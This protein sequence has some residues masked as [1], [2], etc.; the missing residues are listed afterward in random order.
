MP[1]FVRNLSPRWHNEV[2]GTRWFRTD[3][4]IHTLD[5]HPSSNFKFPDGI[6]GAPDDEKTQDVYARALL[7]AAIKAGIEVLGL[8]PH[9]VR[10]GETD[11]SSATWRIIEVWNNDKDDDGVLF[12]DKIYAVFPGFEPNLADG[13]EGLHLLFLFDPEIGRD[14]YLR[15]FNAVMGA[16]PP[17]DG[18]TLRISTNNASDAFKALEEL[19]KRVGSNWDYLIL[20]PHAFGEKGLFSLKSQILQWFPHQKI[21]AFEL[22]DNWLPKDAHEGKPW[23]ANGMKK[24]H[25]ALFHSSD[26]YKLADIGHR[27]TLIKLACPRIE[28]LRQAFLA[29]DSRLRIACCKNDCGDIV[30]S[31]DLPEPCPGS[32]P[33]LKAVTIR[34]GTSFFGGQ[35]VTTGNPK[36]QTFFLNPDLNCLIG[37]RMSGKSTFLDGLRVWFDHDLPKDETVKQDVLDRANKR[38]LSGGAEVSVEIHGPYNPTSPF[39]ERWPALF[40]AQRELQKAVRDQETRRQVLYRL[41]P[42]ETSGLVERGVQ[43]Y[44]LDQNLPQ[45]LN[46]LEERRAALEEAEQE[47][48]RVV[49]SKE[50][51]KRFEGAGLD[52]LTEAQADYGKLVVREETLSR[53]AESIPQL[54]AEAAPLSE[55]AITSVELKEVLDVKKDQSTYQELVQKYKGFIQDLRIIT[56]DIQARLEAAKTA[57]ESYIAKVRAAVQE[58]VIKAGGK[59]EDLNQFSALTASAADYEKVKTQRNRARTA[60]DKVFLEF[61]RT[62]VERSELIREQRSAMQRV[63]DIVKERFPDQIRI[64]IQHDGISDTL[65]RWVLNLSQAGVTRWWNSRTESPTKP[66]SPEIIRRAYNKNDL[67]SIGMSPLVATTFRGLMTAERRLQLAALRNEDKY[68]IQLKVGTGP[69]DY[70]DIDELSGGAQVSVLLSL[71]LETDDT[72]P[73]IVDQPEDEMDKAYLFDVL[74]PA[75]RRLKGRR[76]VILATHDANIVVNGDADNILFLKAVYDTGSISEQGAIE[77]QPVKQAILD[78][79]DG[80]RNAFVLRQAK[81]G[82]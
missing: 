39:R 54:E 12:R 23:L 26:A 50:A 37:G 69:D 66:I 47:F 20:A 5:D 44:R 41:I 71:V 55:N 73:L 6:S 42:T 81:Y 7:N 58:A 30:V 35:D 64:Q 22:K 10:S 52:R 67:S 25:H 29:S 70:R 65:E 8:T 17:W 14:G 3:L 78:T 82:F 34:G 24:H 38:F 9:A 48:Q 75:L 61:A 57:S 16:L 77:E 32:R 45:L 11:Q 31:P 53:I 80:G 15:A 36:E 33:W 40:Y 60:Y 18:A 59:A 49:A 74:L 72:I 43:L 13:D 46:N 27:F 51:L 79:L 68:F 62:H 63:A 1:G 56:A 21:C 4:H 76:Q 2:P 19:H 28:A